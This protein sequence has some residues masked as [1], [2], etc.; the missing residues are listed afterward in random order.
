[1]HIPDSWFEHIPVWFFESTLREPRCESCRCRL[2]SYEAQYRFCSSCAR[3]RGLLRICDKGK[4][5]VDVELHGE[6]WDYCYTDE[7]V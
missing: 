6:R 5:F 2:A 1:M 3:S 4:Q 7:P